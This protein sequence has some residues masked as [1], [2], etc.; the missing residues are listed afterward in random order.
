MNFKNLIETIKSIDNPIVESSNSKSAELTALLKQKK[1]LEKELLKINN[2]I[3]GQQEI[4]RNQKREQFKK[5][6]N[7]DKTLSDL[8]RKYF[9]AYYEILGL[10][11]SQPEWEYYEKIL[12]KL[13]DKVEKLYG[14]QMAKDMAIHSEMLNRVSGEKGLQKARE[15]RNQHGVSDEYFDP[16]NELELY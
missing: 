4:E 14:N 5:I 10:H 1:I 15:F 13:Y 9:D 12:N 8:W 11:D 2:S 7:A 3:L 6:P 16:N